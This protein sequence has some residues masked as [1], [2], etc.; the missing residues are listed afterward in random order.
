M[1]QSGEPATLPVGDWPLGENCAELFS[2]DRNYTPSGRLAFRR[3]LCI[4]V[5]SGEQLTDT[6][7]VG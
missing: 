3:D 7:L 1:L 4:T 6:L 5:Q 2:L